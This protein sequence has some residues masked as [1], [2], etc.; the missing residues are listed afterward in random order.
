M[1]TYFAEQQRHQLA[2]AALVEQC[3]DT[4]SIGSGSDDWSCE[5]D[6]CDYGYAEERDVTPTTAVGATGT[7]IDNDTD[8][9]QQT[10]GIADATAGTAAVDSTADAE[11][12]RRYVLR[13][14][15]QI[16]TA[17]SLQSAASNSTCSVGRQD[18]AVV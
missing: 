2:I 7:S 13:S 11:A 3:P 14:C 4:C 1:Q 6:M 12:P 8:Y 9:E 10:R 17:K 5:S 18:H 16:A 15:V